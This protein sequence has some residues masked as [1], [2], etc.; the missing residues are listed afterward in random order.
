MN[1][2]KGLIIK[3]LMNIKSYK[4]TMLILIGIF[5]ITCFMDNDTSAILKTTFPMV[6][7]IIFAMIGISSFSYDNIS[8]ADK[9]I[10]SFATKKEIVK[11]RYIYIL[12]LSVIG[13]I[14]GIIASIIL[15]LFK[16]GNML[17]L[18][19]IL[20]TILTAILIMIVLQSIQIP[21][22]YKFGAEKGRIIQ[23][24]LVVSI[25][26]VVSAVIVYLI[27]ILPPYSL[28]SVKVLMKYG[29]VIGI[30]V[31]SLLYF[32]SYKISYKIY[33]KKEF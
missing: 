24:L 9:Y 6:I 4:S 29:Y 30:V 23:I 21:I 2:I 20:L 15:E 22:M 14:I 32:I 13:A 25:V 1:I 12:L 17:E 5:S 16:V 7:T 26:T 11:A 10:L 31:I 19:N 3:D 33:L 28:D 18:G 8:K 27:K